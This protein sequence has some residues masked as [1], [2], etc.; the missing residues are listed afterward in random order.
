MFVRSGGASAY[1][2]LESAQDGEADEEL[3][4]GWAVATVEQ[5]TA[6][7][8]R[9]VRTTKGLWLS[10]QD[11][12]PARPSPFH[13]E[14]IVDGRRDFA[15]VLSDR[16]SV[17]P[18]APASPKDKLGKPGDLRVRFQVVRLRGDS[19]PMVELAEGGWMLASDL[20]RPKVAPLPAGITERDERWID[21]DT[22]SQTLVAYQGPRP[23]YATLVSTGLGALR[24]G[25]A[26][27]L[28][29]HRVWVKLM[30]SDMGNVQKEDR[31]AHY[32][33]ED[34]PYVQFFD[35]AVGL[36]GTYWHGDFGHPRSHGCVNLSPLDARWMFD[37]TSPRLPAGWAAAYPTSIEPG[38]LV[39]VR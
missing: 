30:A 38:T 14:S 21:V 1:A 3:E 8:A 13:G 16:A 15:G 11:L 27:P 23:V 6:G 24:P 25:D 19:G 4:G 34:V 9:W 39:R 5:R 7:G 36:H 31:D 20:A 33:L 22:A 29:T 12:S 10:Q 18:A 37:F 28:G 35:E 26:T 2:S 17:W 32:S